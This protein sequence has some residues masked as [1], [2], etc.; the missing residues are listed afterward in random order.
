MPNILAIETSTTVCSV[1]LYSNNTIVAV[2]ESSEPN[3]HSRLLTVLINEILTE[4]DFPINNIDA[5]AVSIGPGSY[6]GLRI[7]VSVA[8]G[9]CYGLSKPAIAVSTLKAMAKQFI[10]NNYD[11]TNNTNILLC[12]M[13][14]ARRLEVYTALYE[15]KLKEILS[16]RPLIID[17]LS[18]NVHLKNQKMFFFG[19]GAEKCKNIIH[20]ENAYF[21][22]FTKPSAIAVAQ[23]AQEMYNK[24]QFA[25]VAYFEPS[26][27]K[28]F[29]AIKSTKKLY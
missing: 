12:P 5:F 2:K 17:E 28:D 26:Y 27:L 1:V 25:D 14:D 23:I 8:K 13:I 15:T 10:N 6:T 21:D 3:A 24:K 11:V 9:L 16:P 19:D 7:G 20:S 22:S 18:F 29:I 4:N